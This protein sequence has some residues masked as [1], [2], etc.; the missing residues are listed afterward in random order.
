MHYNPGRN[1]WVR[2][3]RRTG[4]EICWRQWQNC[5][6]GSLIGFREGAGTGEPLYATDPTSGKHLQPG[7]IPASNEEVDLAVRLAADAFDDYRRAPAVA[8]GA[9]SCAGLLPFRC[10]FASV[11]KIAGKSLLQPSTGRP[12]RRR[13]IKM[14]STWR[15]TS[16]MSTSRRNKPGRLYAYCRFAVMDARCPVVVHQ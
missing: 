16:M 5:Q 4:S 13:S 7:F 15:L 14:I 12:C 2:M 8:T 6:A 10:Q 11:R 9:P 1:S 3:H